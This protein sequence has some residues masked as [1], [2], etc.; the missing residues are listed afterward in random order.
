VS[1]AQSVELAQRLARALS[2]EMGF[3]IGVTIA[4]GRITLSGVADSA[5]A[6]ASAAESVAGLAPGVPIQNDITIAEGTTMR[7]ENGYEDENRPGDMRPPA[8]SESI[9]GEEMSELDAGFTDQPLETNEINVA[10][11]S[12]P[13]LDEDA[14]PDPTFFAPTDPVL[15]LGER[16]GAEV[17]GGF[18]P[19]SDTSDE[20]DL[21]VEDHQPG[22]EAIADAVRR[23]LKEDA[24]TTDL[25]I[26]VVV[27]R[28]VVHLQGSV[29]SQE[30]AEG[31]QDVASRVPGVR[32]VLDELE[33]P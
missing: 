25:P 23:E 11:D 17:L 9:E 22:D 1:G 29:P 28:G 26:E 3:P 14:E 10:N 6:R 13:D 24:L 30:E 21:S 20:V 33:L 5:E 27:E 4:E 19:T 12:I 15:K 8:G 31:A 16:G 32:E 18:T 7:T 2:E